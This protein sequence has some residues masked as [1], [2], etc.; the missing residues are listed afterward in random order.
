AEEAEQWFHKALEVSP[1]M[2]EPYLNLGLL[3]R[4]RG[5]AGQAEEMYRRA[6]ALDGN[7]YEP[8]ANLAH[9]LLDLER[10]EEAAGAFEQ[11]QEKRP[12]LLDV[13]LGLCVGYAACGQIGRVR[14]QA[15]AV[16]RVVYGQ[17]L[18]MTLP[19]N[20]G[21]AE[22]AQLLAES[23]RMLLGRQLPVCA[24]LAYLAAYLLDSSSK[25]LTLQLAEIFRSTGE[26]H[27]AVPLYE[28]LIQAEPSEA[29]LFRRLGACYEAMGVPEAVQLCVQQVAAL[30]GSQ[31]ITLK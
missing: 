21:A 29:D 16:L 3:A 13:D 11:V 12:G 22:L 5:D 27:R 6:V 30:E 7:S 28:L 17:A 23:G 2:P 10:Y 31:A 19:P 18:Q 1:N 25:E 8:L 24:R 4:R 15:A 26:A 14:E 9:L 20:T